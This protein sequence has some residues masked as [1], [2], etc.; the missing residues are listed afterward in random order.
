M[1]VM[2]LIYIAEQGTE[3]RF[4]DYTITNDPAAQF[5]HEFEDL[6][7]DVTQL[8]SDFTGLQQQ[9]KIQLEEFKIQLINEI[10]LMLNN[11]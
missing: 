1:I 11:K 6:R 4:I 9:I 10:K 2:P 5:R 8:R 3:H 7:A